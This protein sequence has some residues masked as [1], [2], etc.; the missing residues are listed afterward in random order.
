VKNYEIYDT[1]E[2]TI[3]S[4]YRTKAEAQKSLDKLCNSDRFYIRLS[5]GE[6]MNLLNQFTKNLIQ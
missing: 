4:S 3:H 5:I 2:K 1:M 6:S